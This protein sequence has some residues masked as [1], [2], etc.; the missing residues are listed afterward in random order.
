VPENLRAEGR[1]NIEEFALAPVALRHLEGDV[2][3]GGRHIEV[4]RATAQFFGGALEGSLDAQLTAAPVYRLNLNYSRVDLA[5]L[6]SAFPT[7]ADLFAGSASG[8]FTVDSSGATRADLVS[9]LECRGTARITDAKL[10][11]ISLL[12]SLREAEPRA[13]PSSFS[14]ASAVFACGDEKIF[15]QRLRFVGAAQDVAGSGSV[16]FAHNLDLRLRVI[17]ATGALGAPHTAGNST[18]LVELTGSVRFPNIRAVIPSA[19]RAAEQD[20]TEQ[21]N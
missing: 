17:P 5:A 16:D 14:S 13:G 18:K 6:S 20:T 1:I 11:K 9:S 10:Q 21:R 8:E 12:E 4:S 19:P 2:K 3:I 15:F 7:L